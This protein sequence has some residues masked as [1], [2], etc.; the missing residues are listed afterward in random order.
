LAVMA[1]EW[2]PLHESSVR[3]SAV[4]DVAPANPCAQA[5]PERQNVQ[6]AVG[7]GWPQS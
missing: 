5:D 3:S 6:G 2:R 7:A 4:S 1:R